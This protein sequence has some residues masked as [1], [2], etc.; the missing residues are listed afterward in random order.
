MTEVRLC[1]TARAIYET[2]IKRFGDNYE[3]N[4]IKLTYERVYQTL[5]YEKNK[6]KI[7]KYQKEYRKANKDQM[8]EY[9]K[10]YRERE[11]QKYLQV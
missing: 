7:K 3:A 6:D 1:D 9:Q 2:N 5:Q 11:R 8:K 10:N 4:K